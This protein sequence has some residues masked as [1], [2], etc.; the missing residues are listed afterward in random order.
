MRSPQGW[1]VF[2]SMVVI[3]A[4]LAPGLAGSLPSISSVPTSLHLSVRAPSGH[5]SRAT[6]TCPT[7]SGAGSS[8]CSTN[9]A[10][11]ADPTSNGAVT[12]VSGSW[13]VPSLSCPRS[14]TTY[15]AIWV[16]IDGYSSSTVEQT[17]ILGECNRGT[18]SY[19]AW[20]EFYPS[21]MVT[22]SSVTVAASDSVAA[23]VSYS[24]STGDYTVSLS[25]NSGTAST[26]SSSVSSAKASSA[27]WIVERPELCSA[28][29]CSLSTLADFSSAGFTGA[30]ATVSGSSGSIS[31]VSDAAI[32]MVSGSSGPVLAEPSSLGSSGS[33]F[34]VTYY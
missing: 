34:S 17:G 23:S 29:S 25:V 24:S 2:G 7:I 5:G 27:E 26:A 11:Y 3:A 15:V 6:F 21:A 32:T 28:R 22:F 33:S 8:V 1:V 13:T 30:A 18:A 20:Y 14:G 16:G 19:A 12:S 10:G 31:A 9:W 4:F